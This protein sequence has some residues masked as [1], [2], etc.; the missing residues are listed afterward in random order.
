MIEHR[1]MYIERP[2]RSAVMALLAAHGPANDRPAVALADAGS[3]FP[4]SHWL[5]HQLPF[6]ILHGPRGT[7][8]NAV[9]R[10]LLDF[11]PMEKLE[12]GIVELCRDHT[13]DEIDDLPR[14]RVQWQRYRFPLCERGLTG[15]DCKAWLARFYPGRSLA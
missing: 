12:P 6:A 10:S 8:I 7:P 15:D 2:E 9:V 3:P 4:P 11:G 13:L 14:P 5:A 1:L